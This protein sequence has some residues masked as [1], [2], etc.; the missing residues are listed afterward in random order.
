[1][2]SQHTQSI[3]ELRLRVRHY[4]DRAAILRA[5]NDPY[6]ATMSQQADQL[7]DLIRRRTGE[8]DV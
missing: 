7:D 5:D 6:H 4:R 1:M 2:M 3:D 8:G